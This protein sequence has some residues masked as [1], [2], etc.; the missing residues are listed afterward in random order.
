VVAAQTASEEDCGR[1]LGLRVDR[2]NY[3]VVADAINGIYRINPVNG[4][5][6]S[7]WFSK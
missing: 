3:L 1:P 4:K 2:Q 5:L 6:N 7:I